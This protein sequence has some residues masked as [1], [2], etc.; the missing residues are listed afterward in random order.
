MTRLFGELSRRIKSALVSVGSQVQIIGSRNPR[1]RAVLFKPGRNK[2][3]FMNRR[4]P[5][6]NGGQTMGEHTCMFAATCRTPL[7]RRAEA[8][9]FRRLAMRP[10]SP[11]LGVRTPMFSI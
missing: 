3:R 6:P 10:A 4:Q 11:R 9:F 7:E 8:Q 1:F 2:R 5:E